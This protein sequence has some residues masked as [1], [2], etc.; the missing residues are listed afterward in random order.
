MIRVVDKETQIPVSMVT[1]AFKSNH[2]VL[3][4]QII[5]SAQ[6]DGI[7]HRGIED[8]FPISFELTKAGY[9]PLKTVSDNFQHEAD[10]RV[11]TL[12]MQPKPVQEDTLIVI[13]IRPVFEY[14]I[15][16]GS[17]KDM[18]VARQKAEELSRNDYNIDIYCTSS[19]KGR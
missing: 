6:G 13:G 4:K 19:H 17:F 3:D 2:P 11:I 8:P 14:Y 16:V 7:L 18:S 12:A 15:I 10:L 9:L 1:V 5:T